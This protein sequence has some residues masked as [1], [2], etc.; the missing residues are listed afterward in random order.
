MSKEDARK[1][2]MDLIEKKAKR[3][4]DIREGSNKDIGPVQEVLKFLNN[5][6]KIL[7]DTPDVIDRIIAI[8][9]ECEL[10]NSRL[11]TFDPHVEGDVKWNDTKDPHHL[12]PIGVQI[13]WSKYYLNLHPDSPEEEYIDVGR[14]LLD[15]Y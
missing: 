3:M 1:E 2:V 15:D 12:R 7:A 10:L 6:D 5:L 4:K 8:E 9:S 11:K 13:K 14:L